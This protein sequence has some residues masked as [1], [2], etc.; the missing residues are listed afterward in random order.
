M[1][2]SVVNF[3]KF[4]VIQDTPLGAACIATD[5]IQEGE[6]I[7]KMT[8]PILSTTDF[9]DKYHSGETIPL[10]IDRHHFIDL[11]DPY[12][13]FNHSCEPNAGMRN[14]G[15]LFAL[16]RIPAGIEIM[17]DYSTTADDGI[18]LME[19]LC[20]KQSCR[21]KVVDFQSIPHSRKEF[22]LKRN[23]LTSHIKNVYY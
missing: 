7:C 5:E 22:Y 17:F 11:I 3:Y 4:K 21:K 6:I 23:A 16:E 8:G 13:F 9:F 20:G 1:Q 15:I 10:Q 2:S 19:C 12:C 14:N 18:L